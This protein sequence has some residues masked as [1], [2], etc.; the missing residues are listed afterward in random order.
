MELVL[1]KAHELNPEGNIPVNFHTTI[2]VPGTLTGKARPSDK[3]LTP[4]EKE[5]SL[6]AS[7]S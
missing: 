6:E 5:R 4:E 2:G 7:A 1:E 3:D